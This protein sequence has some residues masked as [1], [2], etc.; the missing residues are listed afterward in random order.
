MRARYGLTIRRL[1]SM[2]TRIAAA[3]EDTKA[4]RKIARDLH[5]DHMI[6]DS[7]KFDL[8]RALARLKLSLH[9]IGLKLHEL[10]ASEPDT[11]PDHGEDG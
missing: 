8:E 6:P 5:A 7:A 2:G 11:I 4:A 9:E 1:A 10:G 3:I